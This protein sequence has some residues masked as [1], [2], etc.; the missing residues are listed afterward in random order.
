MISQ[1]EYADFLAGL[2]RKPGKQP[3]DGSASWRGR[4]LFFK[5]NC[6]NC[7]N[8]ESSA[9]APS[10]EGIYDQERVVRDENGKSITIKAND[11]YI[12]NSIRVPTKHVRDGWKPIMPAFSTRQVQEDEL[13]DLIIYIKSL[14]PGDM[15]SRNEFTPA[16]IGAPTTDSL[17]DQNPN[18]QPPMPPQGGKN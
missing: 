8:R 13:R 15:P 2:Y 4:K 10:L 9:R 12:A 14:K 6:I 16:P 17:T 1:S 5:L 11:E 7:H 3:T 18:P